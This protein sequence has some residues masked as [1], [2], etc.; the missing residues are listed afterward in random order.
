[1]AKFF[2]YILQGSD[3]TEENAIQAANG[4]DWQEI[5]V[6]DEDFPNL[7]YVDTV[8]GVGIYYNYGHDAYY[9]TDESEDGEDLD[10]KSQFDNLEGLGDL[11]TYGLNEN[12]KV[13]KITKEELTNIIR[14]GVAKLHKKSL[15][16]NRINQINKELRNL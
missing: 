8:N 4:L 10:T 6:S 14:E 12:K 13:I 2:N 11:G 15:I 16:E 1:M 9:F 3:A 7:Q 5:E